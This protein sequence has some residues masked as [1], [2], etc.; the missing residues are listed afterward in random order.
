VSASAVEDDA[1]RARL[2][3][4]DGTMLLADLVVLS[5]GIRPAS[6][7]AREAGLRL[8]P[9]GGLQVDGQL[10]TSDPQI[11]AAGDMVEV[12][13]TV[14]GQPAIIALAGPANRQGR[15]IA[16]AIAGMRSAYFS[17]QGTA[18]IKVL[19]RTAAITGASEKTLQRLGRP[20]RKIYLHPS[21]HAGYYPGAAPMQIKLLFAPDDGALLGAQIV[22]SEGVDKRIDVLA[23]ALRARM[24]VY[25]LEQL[26]LAYAPPYGSAKDPVNLA[27]FIAANLLRGDVRFWYA[28]EAQPDD[29]LLVDVRDPHEYAAG[30][31]VG[32]HNIPLPQLRAHLAELATSGQPVRFYC[33]V[34]F[35]SYL[36]Y[37]MLVQHGATDV[38]TLG[39]GLRTY[40]AMHAPEP[41][42]HD[43]PAPKSSAARIP[44][45]ALPA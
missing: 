13:D 43:L 3:L 34:G 36:A 40:G 2:T 21:S 45:E 31:I 38:A 4:S 39:G 33:L 42:S 18:I 10:R 27:G 11:Y 19:E 32:A 1:G 8:G 20:Y 25:D 41:G 35:R 12:I 14:T 5:A 15:I 44:A 23:T 9:R 16:D 37:R 24:T 30:H 6:T 26:E 7:L 17:T 29:I 22:G 28:E